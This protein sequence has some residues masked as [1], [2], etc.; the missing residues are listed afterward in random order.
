MVDQVSSA[1]Y[2][3]TVTYRGEDAL[4]EPR[5]TAAQYE[6]QM[7]AE[8]VPETIADNQPV[9]EAY[10]TVTEP[11]CN[12][13]RYADID[14]ERLVLRCALTVKLHLRAG[15]T[16]RDRRYE[17]RFVD[18]FGSHRVAS[19]PGTDVPSVVVAM[20]EDAGYT[21]LGE[22]HWRA[23]KRIQYAR[24]VAATEPGDVLASKCH[25]TDEPGQMHSIVAEVTE[26]VSPGPDRVAARLTDV[27]IKGDTDEE[28]I[29]RA[30]PS[31]VNLYAPSETGR[32]AWIVPGGPLTIGDTR[33][34]V[35]DEHPMAVEQDDSE[36]VTRST[37]Q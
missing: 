28:V 5:T 31:G 20:V 30:M 8:G 18:N 33:M 21:Y 11:N 7:D 1:V 13:E 27:T 19:G 25:L 3:R 36:P 2:P 35:I 15:A 16:R 17:L 6:V 24:Q 32:F 26:V 14:S 4:V 9:T 29:L 22:W 37:A 23:D 10:A 12:A 34:A